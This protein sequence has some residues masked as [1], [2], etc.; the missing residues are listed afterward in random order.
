MSQQQTFD[1]QPQKT[2][3]SDSRAVQ[4]DA[5]L[6][7][8]EQTR[9]ELINVAK[10]VALQIWRRDGEVSSPQVLA[11]MKRNSTLASKIASVD[12]RFMGAVFRKG[13]G[14]RRLRFDPAGSHAQPISVW[15]FRG[16]ESIDVDEIGP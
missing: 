1:F 11:E 7:R 2:V 13:N 8:L 3:W 9:A 6:D 5:V 4:R 15:T 16:K 10:Q 14:W 12:K